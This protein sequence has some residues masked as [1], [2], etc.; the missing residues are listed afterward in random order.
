MR[1]TR[2]S[3]TKSVLPAL[4][5]TYFLPLYLAFF[6]PDFSSRVDASF[7]WQLFPVYLSVLIS[8]IL[9]RFVVK[10]TMKNDRIYNFTGDLTAIKVTVGALVVHSAA[11]W[12]YTFFASA[13]GS[14]S[15]MAEVV[16]PPFFSSHLVTLGGGAEGGGGGGDPGNDTARKLVALTGEFLKWDSTFLFGNTFLWLGCLFWDI[17]A[18]GMLELSWFWILLGGGVSAVTF[19]PGAA[20]GMGW[21]WREELLIKRRHRD[22]V[23][24]E[25]AR[26]LNKRLGVDWESGY[27]D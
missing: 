15:K 16:L 18:A 10:D 23:T 13:G 14:P 27:E 8:G 17:K 21:L 22:A 24:E 5:L 7:V 4:V 25:K 1:L 6:L 11:V 3:Y 12:L 20:V 26:E 9:A 2:K 19:G